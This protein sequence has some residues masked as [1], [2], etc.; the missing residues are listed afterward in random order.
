MKVLISL[1]VQISTLIEYYQLAMLVILN[2]GFRV[3]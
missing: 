1:E 2:N 3:E